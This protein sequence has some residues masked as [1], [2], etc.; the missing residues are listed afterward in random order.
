MGQH[1]VIAQRCDIS[2]DEIERVKVGPDDPAWSTFDA[3][4][5]RAADEL[6]DDARISDATWAVLAE[7]YT[8]EQLLDAV[9]AVGQYHLVSMALNTCGV[10]LD[11]GIPDTL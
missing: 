3:A 2:L 8:T 11:D 6:H 5:L 4:L 7:R 1:H 9:F 10:Q